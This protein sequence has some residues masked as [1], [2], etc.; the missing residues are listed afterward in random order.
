MILKIK[1]FVDS[2]IANP[3]KINQTILASFSIL[4]IFALTFNSPAKILQT[5]LLTLNQTE[6]EINTIIYDIKS[7]KEAK[8]ECLNSRKKITALKNF[9]DSFSG[10][11]PG[12]GNLLLEHP[13]EVTDHKEKLV[14]DTMEKYAEEKFCI[15]PAEFK[16]IY[17]SEYSSLLG[18]LSVYLQVREK[19]KEKESSLNGAEFDKIE[20]IF[21][22]DLVNE[23]RL[24]ERD[25]NSTQK[26]VIE[27]IENAIT[28]AIF[29]DQ[30]TE[31][32][33]NNIIAST[34]N[35][36]ATT[37]GAFNDLLVQL[38]N[39]LIEVNSANGVLLENLLAVKASVQAQPVGQGGAG[40]PSKKNT[41]SATTVKGI[42]A[43]NSFNQN[44]A[45][46]K[47]LL[48]EMSKNVTYGL[49]SLVDDD[50]KN[51]FLKKRAFM[52]L[53]FYTAARYGKDPLA[54]G[55]DNNM[56]KIQNVD[57]SKIRP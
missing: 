16:I 42:S 6:E 30:Q 2:L 36:M 22:T 11:L 17:L 19:E 10:I 46:I 50:T 37:N 28:S 21:I 33:L 39:N 51:N 8:Q 31:A 49:L 52:E 14:Y 34:G 24:A 56:E 20:T 3:K 41:G 45:E 15:P 5:R 29:L 43:E 48:N 53:T 35:Q 4:G 12:A 32:R 47:P 27:I 26:Y 54:P 25:L 38:L 7:K 23:Y 55:D 57:L 13:A 44:L 40:V 9:E 1:K 18:Q